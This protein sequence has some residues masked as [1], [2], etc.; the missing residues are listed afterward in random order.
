MLGWE[1]PPHISGG[2][3]TACQGL[4]EGLA[5]HGV[6]ISFLV[7][8]AHGDEEVLGISLLGCE[9]APTLASE[10]GGVEALAAET[11]L[12]PYLGDRA[13]RRHL[14][15]LRAAATEG[16][17][18][19]P[20]YGPDI[21]AEVQRYAQAARAIAREQVFDL[22]HAHDWMTF[23]AATAVA[24]DA[25]VPLVVHV[26][27]CEHDRSGAAPDLRIQ[28]IEQQ[29]LRNADAIVCVSRYAARVLQAHYEVDPEKLHIVHNATSA[30]RR[31][32]PPIDRTIDEPIVLFLGRVTFQKGPG[33]FLLAAARVLREMARV[34]FVVAGS[35]DLLHA[36]VETAAALGIG[37][38]VHFTGFLRGDDLER[39]FGLADIYVMPSVSEPFGI[40]PLEAAERGV[41]VI[42]SRQSGVAEV[43]G[44]SLAVNHWDVEALAQAIL[45]L[46]RSPALR[47]RMVERARLEVDALSW[48]GQALRVRQVYQEVLA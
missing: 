41:P 16:E 8:R 29:G 27:S 13:Y 30:P 39:I 42:L 28:A 44:S 20:A 26:H 2:L 14:A 40:S 6:K 36:M 23:E 35:G 47:R 7:P 46:L 48:E 21:F 19:R 25:G 18:P 4:T 34:K 10:D 45:A 24:R 38:Q 22:V 5:R 15:R 17:R 31:P 9:R 32:L 37:R 3:G 11:A 43:L 33:W 1:Y 12:L